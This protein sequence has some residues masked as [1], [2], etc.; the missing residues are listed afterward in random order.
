M[1]ASWRRA[2][3]R[4]SVEAPRREV[5]YVRR[6]GRDLFS[7]LVGPRWAVI[8]TAVM[9]AI[10][11]VGVVLP[12]LPPWA[13][14]DPASVRAWLGEQE[15]RLGPATPWLWRLGLLDVFRAPWFAAGLGLMVASLLAYSFSRLPGLYAFIFRPRKWPPDVYFDTAPQRLEGR[16]HADVR[17]LVQGLRRRLYRVE[18]LGDEAVTYLFADRFPWAH[19]GTLLAH[20]AV[21]VLV[22]AAAVGRAEAFSIPLMVAEGQ[23]RPVFPTPA[24]PRQMEVEVT[25]AWARFDAQGLPLQYAAELTIF[26]RGEE[27][28]RCRVTVN[29]PCQYGGY[30][31]HLAAYFGFGAEVVVKEASSGR[32]IYHE[33]VALQMQRPAPYL[34][35]WEEGTGRLAHEGAVALGNPIATGQG[36]TSSLALLSVAG[37]DWALV[38]REGK[39]EATL[40]IADAHD[41]SRAVALAPGEGAS[42]GG[43]RWELVAIQKAPAAVVADMPTPLGQ[44]EGL[45][46]QMSNVAYGTGNVSQGGRVAV[47]GGEGPPIL[48][49]LGLGDRPIALQGGEVAR[50][51]QYEYIFLGQRAFVGIEVRRDPSVH[52]V[53]A[54]AALLVLSLVFTF[55]LP[56]RRLWARLKGEEVCI[57]EQGGTDMDLR[58]EL[59]PLLRRAG[60]SLRQEVEEDD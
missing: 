58:R 36:L 51:G 27:V 45:L 13:A 1:P 56:R 39:G 17:V 53:W 15:R 25:R 42:L 59:G 35:A 57:V 21:V 9:A 10:A 26:R 19:A 55:W 60:V 20:V 24:H 33:T 48:I 52:L 4:S 18:V 6:W 50:V 49:L 31:F 32:A 12:Q 29:S 3:F 14:G 38:L 34:R 54:G 43:V 16:G 8:I 40:L 37:R 44:G 46:L 47:V 28:A 11:L 22:L 30:R 23:V 41:L 2:S 7:F 5:A